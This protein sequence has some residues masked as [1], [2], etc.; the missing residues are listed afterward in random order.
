MVNM[1]ILVFLEFDV[2]CWMVLFYVYEGWVFSSVQGVQGEKKVFCQ[3]FFLYRVMEYKF[4]F[5]REYG[6]FDGQRFILLEGLEC[7]VRVRG[8]FMYYK[9]FQFFIE[10]GFLSRL[11][12]CI[13]MILVWKYFD[14]VL[15]LF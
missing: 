6:F 12:Q 5:I 8:F 10:V 7:L 2:F 1:W 13:Y 15:V 14:I 11:L 9:Y 3:K 4:F